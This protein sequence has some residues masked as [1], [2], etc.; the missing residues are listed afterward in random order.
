MPGHLDRARIR[1]LFDE[2]AAELQR[3]NQRAHVYIVG[4]AAMAMQF[5]R[6]RTTADVDG[7]IETAQEPVFAAA[8]RVARR[9]GL[10]ENWLNEGAAVFMP[11]GRD[12]RAPTL[13]NTPYL[14]VTGA[15]A[16]HLLAMKLEAGRP[17]D[18]ADVLTLVRVL[19][20]KDADEAV[21]IHRTTFPGRTVETKILALVRKMIREDARGRNQAGIPPSDPGRE[22]S[23]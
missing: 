6:T 18:A 9:R 13:Y 1:E 4:G 20:L 3:Q 16:E 12:E 8:R 14:V 11:G 2:L 23:R 7:R 19:R 22:R 17:E 21:R 10:P 5:D 15:S